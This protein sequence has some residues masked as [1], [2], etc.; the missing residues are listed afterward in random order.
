MNRWIHPAWWIIQ[1]LLMKMRLALWPAFS[2]YDFFY[3]LKSPA[4]IMEVFWAKAGETMTESPVW[5]D[6][7]GTWPME[8]DFIMIHLKNRRFLSATDRGLV[9]STIPTNI[10][11]S[12]FCFLEKEFVFLFCNNY[13]INIYFLIIMSVDQINK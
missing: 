5:G 7:T 2:C 4:S 8:E 9:W 11:C 12:M 10:T 6:L 13:F 3:L 1:K